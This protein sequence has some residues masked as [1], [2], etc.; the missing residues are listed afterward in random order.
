M[1]VRTL[2][3]TCE[4]FTLLFIYKTRY[5][6]NTLGDYQHLQARAIVH[7]WASALVFGD[8]YYGKLVSL[9]ALQCE[10]LG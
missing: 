4:L 7:V 9:Q 5:C 1:H 2:I 8:C 6:F 3:D 10:S